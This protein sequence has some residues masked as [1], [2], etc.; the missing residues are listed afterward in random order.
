MTKYFKQGD[1]LIA[2]TDAVEVADPW[3][4]G[5]YYKGSDGLTWK[6]EKKRKYGLV[7]ESLPPHRTGIVT[8]LTGGTVSPITV[9]VPEPEPAYEAYTLGEPFVLLKDGPKLAV[10]RGLNKN[11]QPY[12]HTHYKKLDAIITVDRIRYGYPP[13]EVVFSGNKTYVRYDSYNF[14]EVLSVE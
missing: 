14:K 13:Y 1:K 9:E 12:D 7:F 2:L 10:V 6:L 8:D 5:N 4:V 3:V 11:L